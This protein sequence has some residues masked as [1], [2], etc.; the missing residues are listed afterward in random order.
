MSDR[1]P[2]HQLD[3]VA[4]RLPEGMR[5]Q[6]QEAAAANGRSMNAEIVKR[7]ERSF[8]GFFGGDPAEDEATL[9]QMLGLEG[10][11]EEDSLATAIFRQLRA[12]HARIGQLS[13]QVKTLDAAD[14]R[15][16][17]IKS[18]LSVSGEQNETTKAALKS[19]KPR[20]RKR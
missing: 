17:F 6:L 10:A 3:K 9:E 2:S 20:S 15:E 18:R 11:S 5:K 12:L 19:R 7:L 1:F 14:I 8:V 16:G 13:A 4:L